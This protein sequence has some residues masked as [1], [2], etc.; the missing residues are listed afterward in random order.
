MSPS[1]VFNGS[2]GDGSGLLR[3][4]YEVAFLGGFRVVVAC[5]DNSSVGPELLVSDTLAPQEHPRNVRRFRLSPKYR[6]RRAH[7][8]LD[9]GRALEVANRDGP[10]ITDPTQVVY[11]GPIT[12]SSE[13]NDITSPADAAPDRARLF[14]ARRRPNTP[15]RMG[16]RF[17]ACGAPEA[18][19]SHLPG[20][21][22]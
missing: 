4:G 2:S 8:R 18:I 22:S 3:N 9:H 20:Y 16:E 21:H 15:G 5:C 14:N 6:D 19:L 10:L 1:Q 11:H 13:T 17:C 7:L 12:Q